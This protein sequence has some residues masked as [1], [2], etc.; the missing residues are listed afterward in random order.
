MLEIENATIGVD[1]NGVTKALNNMRTNVITE[2]QN[3]I[4]K[5]WEDL[6]TKVDD[7]WVGK[8]AEV[9]KSNMLSDVNMVNKA[10]DEA[11]EVLQSELYDLVDQVEEADS[12]LIEGRS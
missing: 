4:R 8:S 11:F 10:L 7:A 12:T 6:Q 9:F 5:N 1:Q 3:A 2:T